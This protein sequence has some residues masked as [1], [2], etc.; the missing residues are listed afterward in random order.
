MLQHT[1]VCEHVALAIAHDNET[2]IPLNDSIHDASVGDAT[3]GSIN[4]NDDDEISEDHGSSFSFGNDNNLTVEL[5]LMSIDEG[6][7][8]DEDVGEVLD[9][10]DRTWANDMIDDDGSD[11]THDYIMDEQCRAEGTEPC[12]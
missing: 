5:S 4:N 11:A 10:D 2:S 8:N 6:D 1:G 12:R 3:F 9:S 7:N